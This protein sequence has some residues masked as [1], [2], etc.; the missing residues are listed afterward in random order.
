MSFIPSNNIKSSKELN[1]N[2]KNEA[3]LKINSYQEEKVQK[4]ELN[5]SKTKIS[6]SN[7]EEIYSDE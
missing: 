5:N 4:K 1:E 3:L 2:L 7:Q 6:S